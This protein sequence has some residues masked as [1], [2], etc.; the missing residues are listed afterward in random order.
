[1]F[2]VILRPRIVFRSTATGVQGEIRP[3]IPGGVIALRGPRDIAGRV[4]KRVRIGAN[5][6]INLRLS[7]RDAERLS[8]RLLDPGPRPPSGLRPPR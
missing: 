7:R 4:P 8:A 6:R 1:M 5:S 3:R 2:G